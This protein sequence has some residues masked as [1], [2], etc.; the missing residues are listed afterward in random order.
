MRQLHLIALALAGAW[1]AS[2]VMAASSFALPDI[3]VALGGTYPLHPEV[4]LLTLSTQ[5]SNVIKENI[6]GDGLLVLSLLTALGHLGTFEADLLKTNKGGT[7]C[8]SEE[9]GKKDPSEEILVKGSW[10]LVYTSLAGSTQGLQLGGLLLVAPVTIKCGAEEVGVK[11]D[12]LSAI[13]SLSGT[14]ATEYTSLTGILKGNGEGSPNVKSFYNEGGTSV[15]VKLEANF[16]TGFKE[17]AEE[18]EGPVTATGV[19]G[20]MFVVTSR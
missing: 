4:T 15:K 20:K 14:E 17:S 12:M 19:G 2:A 10:H 7:L 8:F 1:A 16:G 13:E 18:V 11:G 5:L 3:A 6:R 9:G